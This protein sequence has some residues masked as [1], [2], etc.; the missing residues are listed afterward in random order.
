MKRCLRIIA[1]C[2]LLNAVFVHS[3]AETPSH[4]D[5]S[6]SLCFSDFTHAGGYWLH[7][8]SDDHV[9]ITEAIEETAVN[10]ETFFYTIIPN[11]AGSSFVWFEFYQAGAEQPWFYIEYAIEVTENLEMYIHRA[12]L[13]TH[14][15]YNDLKQQAPA[16]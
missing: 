3:L 6:I 13:V 16:E 9:I 8:C 5:S 14:L 1:L 7:G 15:E 12:E 10:E 2:L 4:P 11:S